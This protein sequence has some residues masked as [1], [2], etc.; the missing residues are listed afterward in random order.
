MMKRKWFC[1]LSIP[2]SSMFTGGLRPMT[3]KSFE[4]AFRRPGPR[5]QPVLRFYDITQVNFDGTNTPGSFEVEIDLRARNWYV[6]LKS[7]ARS[8]CIDLGLRTA[9]GG[10]HRLARSNVAQTPRASPSD[11]VEESYLLVEGDYPR[12]EAVVPPDES[13]DVPM[14]P[15]ETPEDGERHRSKENR[16][17]P[18]APVRYHRVEAA[19]SPGQVTEVFKAPPETLYVGE[20]KGGEVNGPEAKELRIFRT[21]APGEIERKL[22]K[23]Y[24]RIARERSSLV[25]NASSGVEPQPS[26]DERADLTEVSERSF[27]AGISSGQKSS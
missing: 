11:N 8:Y 24:G 10:F 9:G 23:L 6:P 13:T 14:T 3:G 18:T 5:A 27:R 25:L 1:F 16:A 20:Q 19:F 22:A 7:P 15:P 4:R 26:G 17:Q 12:A 2:I 21:A